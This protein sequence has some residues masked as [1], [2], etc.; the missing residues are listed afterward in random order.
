MGKIAEK[1]VCMS[2][3]KVGKQST[4]KGESCCHLNYL[5]QMENWL[6]IVLCNL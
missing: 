1:A 4:F 5:Q 2:E 3:M 6:E